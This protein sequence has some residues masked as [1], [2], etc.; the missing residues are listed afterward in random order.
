MDLKKHKEELLF[1][2]IGGANEIGMN[3]NL[4]HFQGKWLIFDLGIG[5]TQ[6]APGIDIV[7]PDI[8]F[9]ETIKKDILGL[10]LTHAHEDHLGAVQYLWERL[11]V[12][13]YTSVFTAAFLYEKLK[14]FDLEKRVPIKKLKQNQ[15]FSLEP[16]KIKLFEINHSIPEMNAAIISAGE[17]K[18]MHTGDWKFDNNPVIGEPDDLKELQKIGRSKINALIC[19]S[20]NVFSEGRSG[21]EGDLQES[22]IKI[23]GEQKNLVIFATFASNL[24]RVLSV[25]EAARQ[26]GRK[27]V[28]CGR[29][30]DRIIRIGVDLGYIKNQDDFIPIQ[31]MKKQARNKLLI[32]ATGCQGEDR[33]AIYR[34]ADGTHPYVN[35]QKNDTVIFSSKN[36]PGNELKISKVQNMLAHKQVHILTA[37]DQ[38][39]HVSGHPNREEL[40]EMYEAIKPKIAIPVHGET[41]H[42]NEH[43]LF[44]EQL[45]VPQALK[46][47]NGAVVLIRDKEAQIIGE[48]KTGYLGVDGNSLIDLHSPI[49]R[50]RRIIAENGVIIVY[51]DFRKSGQL[52][53]PPAL[54][55]PG[56][57][58][59]KDDQDILHYLADMLHKKINKVAPNYFVK[60]GKKGKSFNQAG[61]L[62][63]IRADLKKLLRESIAKAPIIEVLMT[64]EE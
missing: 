52:N 48:V 40:K 17:Q 25:I 63:E 43:V 1:I 56:L 14:E 15:E 55:A 10:V 44:A 26:S 27:I 12:P 42:L 20:T 45:G 49:L 35:L 59:Q 58:D 57:F 32:L 64:I 7:V 53:M 46:V 5:F 37:R 34:I 36:I 23:V 24:A 51:L 50:E 54:K 2:P 18:I 33:A 30:V 22:L 41:M 60:S 61:L 16:F 8:S 11:E 4:Y 28:A 47:R 29:A 39:V 19:D 3:L 13:V 38:F 6:E 21:S 31:Q 9:L 62:K